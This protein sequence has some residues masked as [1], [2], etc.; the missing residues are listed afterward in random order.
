VL[1][2][3]LAVIDYGGAVEIAKSRAFGEAPFL[4]AAA[5]THVVTL[6]RHE[7]QFRRAFDKFDIVLPDGMPLVWAMN[8][9]LLEPLRDRVYGPTYMLHCL[10]QTQGERWSHAFVGGSDPMLR[11]LTANLTRHFPDLRIAMTYAPPFGDWPAE[12]D[13]RILDN[14]RRSGACFVWIGLGCPKQEFWLT[15][16]KEKL[17]PSVYFAVGAAFPFHAGWVRQAPLWVQRLGLEWLFRV[18]VE[19]RRLFARYAKFNTMFPYY[20]LL[21]RKRRSGSFHGSA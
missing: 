21:D 7:R 8:R 12:E 13:D 14:I 4:I 15:R 1:G 18:A 5:N 3:N 2:T 10:R 17:P 19:P 16:L 9:Q 20:L 6:A 11:Q